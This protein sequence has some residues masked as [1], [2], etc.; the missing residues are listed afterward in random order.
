MVKEA[1]QEDNDFKYLYAQD[2]NLRDRVEFIAKEI[3][4]A[5]GVRFV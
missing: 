4:G 3:Y 2:L 5:A 1:C